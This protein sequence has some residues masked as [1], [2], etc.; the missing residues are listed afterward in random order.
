[1]F[2]SYLRNLLSFLLWAINGNI[3]YHDKE[4]ILS[5]EENYIL[6]APHKTFWDPV[7]LGYAAAPKQFIFMAKKELFKDR[8]FGWWI[9][10]CGAFPIDRQNPGMA[11]IKYPVNMLKKSNRSLVM[12][13]SGSRHSSE[14]KGGVAVIAKSAKVKLMPATYVGPMTIKG[15]LA[16]ERIDVAFGNPIDVSD[17]KRMDDTGTAEVTRRIE[18]EFAHL[19]EYATSFQT[20]K[21]PNVLTYVYRIPVLLLV[22]IILILTYAFSYIA[23]FF[24]KPT[25]QLDK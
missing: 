12:F 10:K 18:V 22:A 2:Y 9:S 5:P 8:G 6:I 20:R 15:L 11:A 16:G 23:S 7:F 24:W 1:M 3:H 4:N 19:D 14:L 25:T 17:I 13:P 21:K